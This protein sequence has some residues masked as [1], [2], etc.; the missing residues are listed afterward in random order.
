[1][2]G[3][4][5]GALLVMRLVPELPLS[6]SLHKYLV[7]LPVTWFARLERHHLLYAIV[8][9]VLMFSF[10]EVLAVFEHAGHWCSRPGA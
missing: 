9:S 6:R 7:E 4:I 3:I 5:V 8:L 10:F 1:M 2:V